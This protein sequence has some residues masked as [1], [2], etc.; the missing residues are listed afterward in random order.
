MSVDYGTIALYGVVL[1]DDKARKIM[2]LSLDKI[3]SYDDWDD[4]F[5]YVNSWGG[6]ED[7]IIFG[8]FQCFSDSEVR[9]VEVG[10]IFP[11]PKEIQEFEQKMKDKPWFK[12]IEWNPKRYIVTYCY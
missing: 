1:Y 12:E 2:D 3:I 8:L 4:Y 10:D 6:A 7:R 5:H 9:A 11:S